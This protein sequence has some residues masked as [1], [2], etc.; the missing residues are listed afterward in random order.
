MCSSDLTYV[1]F[2]IITPDHGTDF[3][4]EAIK[5]GWYKNDDKNEEFDSSDN[6]VVETR[7][8][9]KEQ[10]NELINKAYIS[11]YLTPK[12]IFTLFRQ[13]KSIIEK[14]H[15]IQSG[16]SLIYNIIKRKL[17]KINFIK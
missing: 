6:A 11:F 8:L 10:Q 15:I 12:K 14:W 7:Y 5:K 13:Q 17:I 2:S 9:S 4:K 3:R 16:F 1:S